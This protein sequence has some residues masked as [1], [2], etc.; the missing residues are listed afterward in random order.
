MSKYETY[1][2]S[3]E[4]P[5]LGSTI[6]G[7]STYNNFDP[8]CYAYSP[9]VIFW[10]AETNAPTL[11]WLT[12]WA[13]SA[14]INATASKDRLDVV[15]PNPQPSITFKW[16]VC[17][18]PIERGCQYVDNLENLAGLAL[19]LTT[20]GVNLTTVYYDLDIVMHLFYS[21]VFQYDVLL[22]YSGDI[23][24]FS[25][26]SS[27]YATYVAA[28]ATDVFSGTKKTVAGVAVLALGMTLLF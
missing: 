27:P 22:G 18:L 10:E 1:Q 23:R 2:Q 19:K 9:A 11:S 6:Y 16:L 25:S 12:C 4:E 14:N 17:R 15:F 24:F 8:N 21:Y 13:S 20:E 28:A 5:L 26:S 3:A 7:N